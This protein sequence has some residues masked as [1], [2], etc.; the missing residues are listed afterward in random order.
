MRA[1]ARIPTISRRTTPLLAHT[2]ARGQSTRET[3]VF[4]APVG[5]RKE[6]EHENNGKQCIYLGHGAICAICQD[7]GPGPKS[8]RC[9]GKERPGPLHCKAGTNSKEIEVSYPEL[10]MY[11]EIYADALE[12]RKSTM[13]KLRSGTVGD[14]ND[15]SRMEDVSGIFAGVEH[16]MS[17]AM[18]RTLRKT[19][20]PS[21]R[22]WQKAESGIGEHLFAR[23]IGIIGDP[24]FATP[25]RWQGTGE[26]RVLVEGTPHVRTVSQLW[27]YC[28]YGDPERKMRK[29]ISADE[30][31]GLGNPRA[32]MLVHLLAEAC[33]K[34]GVRVGDSEDE[35][36]AIAKYGQV[37]LDARELYAERAHRHDCVRCGPSGKPALAGSP[38]S[39][40]HAHAAALRKVGKEILRDLWEAAR[41]DANTTDDCS[42]SEEERIAEEISA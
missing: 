24:Y 42:G 2:F 22:A 23:L 41:E 26:N 12:F 3:Q 13:N 10:R 27:A 34:A 35:R 1:G 14:L 32:K 21:V 5:L 36:K 11:A 25:Y 7:R 37:Y 15:E 16:E 39:K 19:V 33:L 8:M 20:G 29:G 18:K 31:A 9:P 4:N 30:L 6:K 28:G 38:L 17:M 40:A